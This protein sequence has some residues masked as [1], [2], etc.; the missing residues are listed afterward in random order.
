MKKGEYVE[1]HMVKNLLSGKECDDIIYT[2]ELIEY[3]KEEESVF[4]ILRSGELEDLSLDGIYKCSILEEKVRM[5]CTG[6]I[7]QRYNGRDGKTLQIEIKNGF[8]KIN[9]K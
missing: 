1:L 3:D 6:R 4:I 2:G 7:R 8:Y 5:E 9:L